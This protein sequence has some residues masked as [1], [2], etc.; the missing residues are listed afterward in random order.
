MTGFAVNLNFY[1][2]SSIFSYKFLRVKYIE[3]CDREEQTFD[4]SLQKN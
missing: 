4:V 1:K 3:V 2:Y